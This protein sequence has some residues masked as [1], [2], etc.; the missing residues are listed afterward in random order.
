MGSDR[1]Q[2]IGV[3]VH[4]VAD[5]GLCGAPVATSIVSDHSEAMLQEEQHLGVPIVCRQR[6]AVAE[7]DRLARAPVLEENRD[8]VGRSD[9]AHVRCLL[10]SKRGKPAEST[11]IHLCLDICREIW[12]HVGY[13]MIDRN[14][15]NTTPRAL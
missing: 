5:A 9:R 10:W 8:A 14:E 11:N 4:V 12:A 6:P 1:S 2:I 13:G 7:D 15:L 3:V